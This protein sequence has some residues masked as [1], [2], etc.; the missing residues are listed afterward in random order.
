MKL[1]PERIEIPDRLI[2]DLATYNSH[3]DAWYVN[4]Q[5]LD[6]YRDELMALHNCDEWRRPSRKQGKNRIW[7]ARAVCLQCANV[8]AIR[9]K[10]IE[11]FDELP[12]THELVAAVHSD[13]ESIAWHIDAAVAQA[14]A[15]VIDQNAGA[16]ND[17]WQGYGRYLETDEWRNKRR[18]VLDRDGGMCQACLIRTAEQV[19]HLTYK[20]VFHEPLFDLISVCRVCHYA[21]HSRDLNDASITKQP[22]FNK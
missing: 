12:L 20:R 5:A 2:S 9:K 11:G 3:I 18:R 16:A 13:H 7:H 1:T 8:K 19:H 17:W 10:D 21:L 15:Y 4:R 6:N 14:E 22:R